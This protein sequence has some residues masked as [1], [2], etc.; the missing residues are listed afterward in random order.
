MLVET[1]ITSVILMAHRM[2]A[3]EIWTC[4]RVTMQQQQQQHEQL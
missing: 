3:A 4:E 1:S 2:L